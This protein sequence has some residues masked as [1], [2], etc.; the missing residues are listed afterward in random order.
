[1]QTEL[2]IVYFILVL[3]P[4]PPFSISLSLLQYFIITFYCEIYIKKSVQ[5][6]RNQMSE[7]S[8]SEHVWVN[9]TQIKN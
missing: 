3:I 2:G 4:V 1:M 6:L 5:H 8:Q 7:F 9:S